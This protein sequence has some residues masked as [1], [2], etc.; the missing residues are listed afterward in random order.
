MSLIHDIRFWWNINAFHVEAYFF[1]TSN[2]KLS[3][4]MYQ[5][6]NDKSEA[7]HKDE[8]A[9]PEENNPVVSYYPQKGVTHKLRLILVFN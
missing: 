6:S 4:S 7:E 2:W 8:L 9:T 3:I 1:L 5:A